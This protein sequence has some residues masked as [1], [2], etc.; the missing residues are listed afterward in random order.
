MITPE[1]WLVHE[2]EHLLVV[3]KPA[4]LNTHRADGYAPDGM[5]EWVQRRRPDR[6]LSILHRLDKATSG[7]LLFG[8]S[9]E[10]NRSLTA[11]FEARTV[12]KTYV[13]LVVADAARPDRL[14]CR[15]PIVRVDRDGRKELVAE[16]TFTRD[17]VGNG[18]ERW[19]AQ[20]HTGRTHQV[21]LHAT[22]LGMP[23]IGDREH[24][25]R[26]AARLFLHAQALRFAHPV[27]GPMSVGGGWPASFDRLLADGLAAASAPTMAVRAAVESR[28]TLFDARVTNAYLVMDR[29]H[30]GVP[31]AR[32][33]RLDDVVFIV[34][35]ADAGTPIDD[36]VLDAL[37]TVLS[38]TAI[39]E[40]RRPA[41]GGTVPAALVRGVATPRFTV[42][43]LG[44]EYQLDL[45]VSPTSTGLFLDQRETRARLLAMDLTS[46]TVL[47]T[48]AHTGSLSVAAAMAGAETLTL[49]LSKHYLDWARENF[50]LNDL[51]PDSHDFI[52]GDAMEWMDR[53]A[54]KGR[55]FDVVLVDPPSS[56]TPRKKGAKRWSVDR[57]LHDLVT[58]ALTLTS[59]GGSLFVSTNMRKM[60]WPRFLGHI[61]RGL[62]V[63]DRRGTIETQTVPVDHRTGPG[64]PAYLKAAWITLAD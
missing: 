54:K 25:G 49:D 40:Q 12:D 42:R 31:A 26:A 28:A 20:P 48:F 16:T 15:E 52:Y 27:D 30:D 9:T 35:Y 34:N 29:D 22:A 47:N 21:R 19:I 50:V 60:P 37:D 45:S 4:G 11:Q 10:A 24:H 55:S 57:D 33:E 46:K 61:D 6:A 2:D 56:S 1:P 41:E 44:V 13:L 38:P 64:D 8:A 7:H 32:V 5:Y 23:I 43:E 58:K 53:L 14:V 3:D 51:D 39:Y 63:A 59:N 18:I 36:P 62:A 17:A